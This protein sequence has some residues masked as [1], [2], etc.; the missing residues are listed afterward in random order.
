MSPLFTGGG[1]YQLDRESPC[2][3]AGD[4]RMPLDPDETIADQGALYYDQTPRPDIGV[5]LDPVLFGTVYIGEQADEELTITNYGEADLIIYDIYASMP[6]IF[7]T[8]FDIADSLVLPGADLVV[9]VSFAPEEATAYIEELTIEN[10]DELIGVGLL[11]IGA[12]LGIGYL[13]K[14]GIPDEFELHP[15]FPNPFNP[16]TNLVFSLPKDSEVSLTIFDAMGSEIAKVTE[17]FKP[18]GHYQAVFNAG[19]LPSGTYFAKLTAGKFEQTQ[20][21]T[22]TK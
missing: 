4:A 1:S 3:D 10:N 8:D 18:A 2:I 11:G 6:D 17:G 9:T 13:P 21:L 19:Q 5:N 14:Y 20:R 7:W 15:A 16:E 12:P 22:L